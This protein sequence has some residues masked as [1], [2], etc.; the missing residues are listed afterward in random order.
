MIFIDTSFLISILI[1]TDVH[2]EEALLL[3]NEI[4]ENKLINNVVLNETLNAFTGIGGKIGIDMYNLIKEAFEIEYL[5]EKDYD[6]AMDIYLN[7]DSYINY[8][9]CTILKSMQKNKIS[10][11]ATF[12]SDF[13]KVKGLEIICI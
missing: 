1:K 2:H 7:Y 10:K 5:S 13:K 8:S 4:Y 11:I 6:D 9:D 3:S 12:D